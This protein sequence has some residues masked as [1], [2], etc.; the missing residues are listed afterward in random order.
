MGGNIIL[1]R[2]PKSRVCVELE[3]YLFSEKKLGL[4]TIS[5][6]ISLK[7]VCIYLKVIFHIKNPHPKQQTNKQTDKQ[8]KPT[9]KQQPK[10]NQKQT[11]T[12]NN[13]QK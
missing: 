13:K 1:K 4:I 7:V 11:T 10:T 9:K 3:A 2:N 8:T 5:K 6:R 12:T